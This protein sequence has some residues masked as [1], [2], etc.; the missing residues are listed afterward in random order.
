MDKIKLKKFVA[1]S[2]IVLLGFNMLFAGLGYY[3]I[4]MF[5][6]FL[7]VIAILSMLVMKYY[8]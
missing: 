6:L 8:K 5:W 2:A 4:L 7:A 3:S 1:I